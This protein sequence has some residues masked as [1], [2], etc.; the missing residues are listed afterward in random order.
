MKISK[1]RKSLNLPASEDSEALLVSS[2]THGKATML[3]GGVQ[4]KH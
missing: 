1:L 2:R 4:E 3:P